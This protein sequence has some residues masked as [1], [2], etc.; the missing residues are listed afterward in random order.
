MGSGQVGL[1]VGREIGTN[2]AQAVARVL[3]AS[4]ARAVDEARA[5]D[6]SSVWGLTNQNDTYQKCATSTAYSWL[7]C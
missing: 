1:N 6:G 7:C 4:Q 3:V 5:V 2:A